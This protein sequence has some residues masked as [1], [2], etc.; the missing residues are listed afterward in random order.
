MTENDLP[1]NYCEHCLTNS[2]QARSW[3]FRVRLRRNN[4][5]GVGKIWFKG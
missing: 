1:K 3:T 2:H 5:T 4:V